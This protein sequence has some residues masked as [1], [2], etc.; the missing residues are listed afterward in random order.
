M[1]KK[2]ALGTC[3]NDSWSIFSFET[4][5]NAYKIDRQVN[6]KSMEYLNKG[7]RFSVEFRQLDNF[8]EWYR[9]ELPY[10]HL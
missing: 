3:S 9:A 8:G 4:S 10:H 7:D 1:E 2:D 5:Q 6:K